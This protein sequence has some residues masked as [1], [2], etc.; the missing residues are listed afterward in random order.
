MSPTTEPA[1]LRYFRFLRADGSRIEVQ[2]DTICESAHVYSLKRDG[3][4]VGEIQTKG[5]M[6]W[7]VDEPDNESGRLHHLEMP[8]RELVSVRA[9]KV[10]RGANRETLSLDGELVCVVYARCENWWIE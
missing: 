1:P 10:D 4:Q 9:D 3:T 5:M 6:A 7:W 2:A 8:D